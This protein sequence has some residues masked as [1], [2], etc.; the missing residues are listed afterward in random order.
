MMDKVAIIDL[1][2]VLANNS[3]RSHLPPDWET[4]YRASI[5]DKPYPVTALLVR[6]LCLSMRI[7]IVTTTSERYRSIVN[8]WLNRNLIP[9]HKLIM[10]PDDDWSPEVAFKK[11]VVEQILG[12][13]NIELVLDD[14]AEVIEMYR[15]F[16]FNCHLVTNNVRG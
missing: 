11:S 12:G 3:W 7:A 2:G 16:G 9:C 1:E 10:R 13:H 15:G 5:D 6:L 14:N 8:E 4:Y